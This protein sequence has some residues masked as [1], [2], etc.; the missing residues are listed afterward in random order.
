MPSVSAFPLTPF[1]VVWHEPSAAASAVQE[2]A[3]Q[4]AWP[5]RLPGWVQKLPQVVLM[6]A[7]WPAVAQ[8][9]LERMALVARFVQQGA[10]LPQEALP[11]S[12][13]QSAST[14]CWLR[15]T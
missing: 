4:Q 8:S 11:H 15:E 9:A 3:P 7:V 6:R 10:R 14:A 5:T 1:A 13:L 12:R 2:Q